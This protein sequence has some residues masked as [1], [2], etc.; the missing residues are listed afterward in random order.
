MGFVTRPQGCVTRGFGFVTRPRGFGFVTRPPGFVQ[1]QEAAS[2][3]GVPPEP[4]GRG[5]L[6][7]K[8]EGVRAL[9]GAED[10]G[11]SAIAAAQRR[12][13]SRG[14]ARVF[15]HRQAAAKHL[16]IPEQH[17]AG[18]VA[19]RLGREM[20]AAHVQDRRAEVHAAGADH[21]IRMLVW[22]A[23]PEARR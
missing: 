20:V 8:T 13:H 10:L 2:P 9:D 7:P 4:Q 6:V 19:Q 5:G 1:A 18:R 3:K 21:H 11:H 17:V 23:P 22:A 16:A 14:V 15:R 12:Q